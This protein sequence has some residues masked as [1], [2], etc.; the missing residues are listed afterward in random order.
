[1]IYR[2]LTALTLSLTTAFGVI[3]GGGEQATESTVTTTVAPVVHKTS[4][5]DIHEFMLHQQ[6]R[7]RK[8][9]SV[10]FWEAVS[11]CEVNHDW[12]DRGY[13]S[14]GL[15]MAQS[16]WNSFGG[17]Q[18]APKPYKATKTQQII[19][20]NRVAFLGFQTRH[21]YTTLD[22]KLNN[23][24]YFRPAVGWRNLKNWG[25]NCVNWKTLKP[26][27]EKYTEQLD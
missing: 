20:A 19:V 16:V 11:W 9:A 21:T 1:M 27:S 25:R 23:K 26:L 12:N 24:P 5:I 3:T 4:V 15:G 22:D 13:F 10:K 7:T 8:V 14:G 6:L 17:K 2:T 18:F